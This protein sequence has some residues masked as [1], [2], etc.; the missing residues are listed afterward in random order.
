MHVSSKNDP[1]VA[2]RFKIQVRELT[3]DMNMTKAEIDATQVTHL[4]HILM[5]KL[6]STGK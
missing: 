4:A 2:G 1:T 5:L 3:G 6:H